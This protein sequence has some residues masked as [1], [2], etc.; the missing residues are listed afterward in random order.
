MKT[1][2]AQPRSA[3]EIP[4]TNVSQNELLACLPLM[5]RA[6][7]A[8]HLEYV[9]LVQGQV[10]QEINQRIPHIYFPVTAVV[11]QLYAL[12]NGESAGSALIGCKGMV[13][14]PVILGGEYTSSRAVV[15]IAGRAWR[16][17]ADFLRQEVLSVKPVLHLMLRFLQ[18]MMT[19]INQTAVCNRHHSTVQQL[20]RWLLLVSERLRTCDLS[21]TQE[22]LAN[23]L[24][25]R[26]ESVT[27]AAGQLQRAGLIRC[28]RGR[29]T[30]LDREGIQLSACECYQVVRQEYARLLPY[31]EAT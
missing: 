21:I 26:R 15:L 4:P 17:Q 5:V 9:D 31:R 8:F 7:W 30:I 20:C 24:G 18:A 28:R 19:Q 12:E 11:A 14:F 27:V 25:V 10:L 23:T 2:L 1:S 16:M 22:V 29:L 3:A 6:R 13:G